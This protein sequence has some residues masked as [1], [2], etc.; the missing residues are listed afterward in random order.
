MKGERMIAASIHKSDAVYLAVRDD[1]RITVE[2][3][4]IAEDAERARADL[5]P[6][7]ESQVRAVGDGLDWFEEMAQAGAG[8][9]RKSD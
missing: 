8:R 9:T 6:G 1:H 5:R 3:F 4:P 7:D 2:G